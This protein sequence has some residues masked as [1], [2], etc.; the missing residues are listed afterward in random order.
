M[1]T[2]HL[3]CANGSTLKTEIRLEVLS[4]FS[5]QSL[6]GQLPDEQLGGLLVTTD[7]TEGHSTG[8][9]SVGLLHT[10]GG[11]GTLSGGFSCQL[12]TRGLASG[13]F[14]GGLLGTSHFDTLRILRRKG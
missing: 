5:D 6:E 14:T 10:A 7:L 3:Q 4:D 11:R 2:P 8:P 12:L 9:V 13:G 1:R